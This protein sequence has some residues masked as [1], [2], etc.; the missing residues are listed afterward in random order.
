MSAQKAEP[1]STSF[2][3]AVLPSLFDFS[4]F[5][6]VCVPTQKPNADNVLQWKFCK[7]I[8][9]TWKKRFKLPPMNMVCTRTEMKIEKSELCERFGGILANFH[10]PET[11]EFGT[12]NGVIAGGTWFEWQLSLFVLMR[13]G[14]KRN[15]K[16]FVLKR[17]RMILF[18]LEIPIGMEFDYSHN[19]IFC[20]TMPH[21]ILE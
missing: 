9:Y 13:D 14:V 11:R 12:P 1:A 20:L 21:D 16:S 10:C 4:F 7:T 8:I 17:C 15:V 19:S 3:F 5:L 2:S 6:R 18:S